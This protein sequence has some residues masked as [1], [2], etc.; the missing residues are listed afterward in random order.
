MD[1]AQIKVGN[2]EGKSNWDTW[3]YKVTNVLEGLKDCLEITEGT[4]A[5][6]VLADGAGD[7]ALATYDKA[8]AEYKKAHSMALIIITTNLCD[9]TLKKVMR[10]K[11]ANEVWQE[12]HRLYDSQSEDKAYNLCQEFFNYKYNKE[13]DM[14]THMSKLK[15]IWSQ[16]NLN[17]K[18]KLPEMLLVIKI[19][20]CLDE[21]YSAFKSSWLLLSAKE[22]TIDNLTQ[23]LCSFENSLKLP[24]VEESLAVNNST[25]QK[26][27]D[28]MKNWT[29]NYCKEK[30]HGVKTCPKWIKDGRPPKPNK[31]QVQNITL[32]ACTSQPHDYNNWYVDNGTTSHI[33]NKSDYLRDFQKFNPQDFTV[34]TADGTVIPALGKGSIVVE[35]NTTGDRITLSDVWLVPALTKNLFS[36]LAA[37]DKMPDSVFT[38]TNRECNLTV[39]GAV[40]LA[41]ERKPHGG[42]YKL[43][44]KVIKPS[45][46]KEANTIQVNAVTGENLLQ[47]YHER[48]AHQNTRH[49][50]ELVKRKFGVQLKPDNVTC[51]ACVYGKAHRLKFGTRERATKPGELIHADVC[52]PF[53]PSGSKYRYFVAFKDDFSSFRYVYFLKNK[54]EVKEKLIQM[55]NEARTAGHDINTL[56]TD[57]GGEFDNEG[58]RKVLSD[59]GILQRLTMPYTPEQ[60]GCSERENRILVEAARS[61]LHA[62]EELPQMLWAELINTAAYILNR[63]GP[64]RIQNKVPYELWYNKEPRITHLRII[65]SPCYAHVPKQNRSKLDKKATKG[66]LIGYENDD[67]FRIWTGQRT[68]RSRDVTFETNVEFN[69][70][71]ETG[72]TQSTKLKQ[73]SPEITIKLRRQLSTDDTQPIESRGECPLTSEKESLVNPEKECPILPEEDE[74]PLYMTQGERESTEPEVQPN[75]SES[76]DI[77]DIPD[78]VEQQEIEPTINNEERPESH[79]EFF[80]TNEELPPEAELRYN[81][82]DRSQLRPPV[83]LN[84]YVTFVDSSSSKFPE[85]YQEAIQRHDSAKWQRAMQ[86]EL[87]SLKEN[88]V[89]TVTDLPRDRKALPCKW[90]FR[91]KYNPDGSVDKYKA[92]L[93]IKG[94]KQRKGVDY[95][96]T[97]SP[98]A[99]MSTIRAL[100]SVAAAESLHLA[101]FDVTTAFL[102]GKLQETIFMKQPDGFEDGSNRVCKLNRSLYGLKQ[103]PRC[104]NICFAEILIDMGFEQSNADPCLFAKKIGDKKVLLTLYVDDGLVAATDQETATN[105]LKDLEGR[106]KITS[107]PASYYLGLEIEREKDGSVFIMQECYTKKILERFKMADCN[108]ISTPIESGVTTEEKSSEENFPYREAVGALAYLMMGT[109]PD[110][111]Y[112]VGVVSRKLESPTKKDWQKVKRIFR[113]L[114]GTLTYGIRYKSGKVCTRAIKGYSDADHGGDAETGRSTTGVACIFAEAIVSWLSQRQTSVAISTTEA[115]IVAASEGARELVWLQRIFRFMTT[116]DTT[117]I[118]FVDNEAA[119]R[120]ANNP[121]F[122]KRTKH[123]RVRHFFVRETVQE[124]LVDVQKVSSADQLADI[125]TKP[126]PKPRLVRIRAELGL[127]NK[128]F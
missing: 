103:A 99:R 25:K 122:H 12:L 76:E 46:N 114:K 116:L 54:S 39:N 80:D 52:G 28:K 89:W 58:V 62:R 42:L 100:L 19:I 79:E 106:L 64:T 95:A 117:P 128:L 15:N 90:V 123:I 87:D 71:N 108:S 109:R 120:L 32:M 86:K 44:L 13:D 21:R 66:R 49:V 29:C 14:A 107:K 65:G 105:F 18:E 69:V 82:R 98:V 72:S 60:H 57:N 68:I 10:F 36:P 96:Q 34:T 45:Y 5:E 16:I 115:E 41:G 1:F 30:G 75:V 67:G 8:L 47:L 97:F 110:I 104:W 102:N 55:L 6:P 124:G 26:Y 74:V 101:Q 35:S 61:M 50:I 2:L 3:K 70:P 17:L 92:R 126:V 113:Y 23:K 20:D 37:Q 88:N 48:F 38:S 93:V 94:F 81:L 125:M 7:A 59:R 24:Q 73:E 43:K 112:A 85:T 11:K 4:K 78:I 56:L 27:K 77:E 127:Q 119:I 51:E 121:E 84:D 31:G 33:T 40:R 83:R 63:T 111:A 22:K 53:P 118:L 91:I 9:D